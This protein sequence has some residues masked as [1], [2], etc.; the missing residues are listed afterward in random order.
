MAGKR[1]YYEILGIDKNATPDQIQSAYRRLAKK[2]HPDLNHDPD[3]PEKFKEVTEAYEVLKDP[4]KRAQYDQFG[5]AAFDNNGANGFQQGFNGFGNFSEAD[6]GDIG[7]IFSQFFGG[8]RSRGGRNVPRRGADRKVQVKLSFDQAVHGTKVDIPL[9]TIETCPHCHGSGARSPEDVTTCPTCKGRGHIRTRRQTIFGVM[10]SDQ[11]CP[12]CNGSGKKVRAKCPECGGNGRVRNRSTISVAIPHG[13]DNDD[14]I[15]ISGK[16]EAGINGG[17]NGDLVIA[18]SVSPSKTFQRKGADV[19]TTINVS[20]VD[21]LLGATATVK[22]IDGDVELDIPP[23]TQP[24]TILKMGGKGILLPQSNRPGDQY[25]TVNVLFPKS[26]TN[27]EKALIQRFDE[28]ESKKP[29]GL[30]SWLRSKIKG[31]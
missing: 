4:Q 8:G 17:P 7:D 31:E 26:L 29:Q 16:G 20:L 24:G 6:F 18:I 1:D 15:R 9:D 3:A 12:D 23:C 13:V 22:T 11:V 10:E 25:V 5:H 19:Y 2:Y 21:A 14:V 27:D 28:I 30:F